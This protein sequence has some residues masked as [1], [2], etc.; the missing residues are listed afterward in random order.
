MNGAQRY[1]AIARHQTSTMSDR[2]S[3]QIEVGE[4]LGALDMTRVHN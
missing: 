2:Q 3:E 4:L 1:I